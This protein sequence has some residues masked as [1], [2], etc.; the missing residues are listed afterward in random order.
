MQ[1]QKILFDTIPAEGRS[2][3]FCHDAEAF[4]QALAQLGHEEGRAVAPL[5]GEVR[6]MR[7][8][9]DVF[10]MGTFASRMRYECVRCLEPF[11]QALAGEFHL[12]LSR[13]GDV[14]PAQGGE[15]ELTAAELEVEPVTGNALDL[16]AILMEQAILAMADYPVCREQCEGLCPNC[17]VPRAKGCGCEQKPTDPRLAVLA[18]LKIDKG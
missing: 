7:S 4:N 18:K 8:G 5:A 3:E 13:G 1:P 16:S 17:G 9:S 10:V 14:A 15:V 11:E 6:L 2:V 12:D